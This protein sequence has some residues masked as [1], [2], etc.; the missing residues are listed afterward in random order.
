MHMSPI[1]PSGNT[2]IGL[3]QRLDMLSGWQVPGPSGPE[4]G[5]PTVPVVQDTHRQQWLTGS[6]W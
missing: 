4:H 1:P 3:Q 2:V 5:D 6:H